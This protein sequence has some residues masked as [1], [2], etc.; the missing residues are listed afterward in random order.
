MLGKNFIYINNTQIPT[1]ASFTTN[2]DNI[3]EVNQTEGGTDKVAVTRLL[4]QSLSLTFQVTDFWKDKLL[5]YGG[6]TTVSLKVGSSGTSMTG[7]FRISS[8]HMTPYSNLT[9]SACW[10]VNATFT[11]I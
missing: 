4:K 9:Q 1:P 3:E 2:Y 5:Q 6:Q 11:Q 10:T 7:R 8:A